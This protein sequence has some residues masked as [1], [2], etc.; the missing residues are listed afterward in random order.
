MMHPNILEISKY[1]KN[2]TLTYFNFLNNERLTSKYLTCFYV[3]LTS[4][5]CITKET[6]RSVKCILL[7]CP[8]PTKSSRLVWTH[9][10]YSFRFLKLIRLL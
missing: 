10:L 6:A 2:K 4:S 3:N 7:D 5:L 9:N 1:N 8:N